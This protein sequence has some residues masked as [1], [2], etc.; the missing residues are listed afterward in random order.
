M[1][2]SNHIGLVSRNPIS[3]PSSIIASIGP[4]GSHISFSVPQFPICK[5]EI[6]IKVVILKE[7][8]LR[9]ERDRARVVGTQQA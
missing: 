8:T 1:I 3:Y 6:N 5:M 9:L 4:Q 7:I 2:A